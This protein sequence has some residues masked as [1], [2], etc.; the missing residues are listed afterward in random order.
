MILDL[1]KTTWKRVKFGDV[2]KNV[3][4][5]SSDPASDG[6][7]RVIAMEHLDPGELAILRWG[8]LEAGTT[9]TRRVTPGQTLFGKRRAYQRKVAYAEFDAICSG[10]ILTFEAIPGKLLP[11]LLPFIVQS[12]PFFERAVGTSAGSL[13]P[14]TNWRDLAKFEFDLPPLDQQKR[15]VDLLWAVERHSQSVRLIIEASIPCQ[16][17][18]MDVSADGYVELSDVLSVAKSGGTPRRSNQENY[19]GNIPWLKSGEV[20]GGRITSTEEL[21][22]DTGLSSSAAWLAPEGA[23]VVAMYGDGKT[24]GQVGRLATPM[25]TN[26]AVLALVADR[27]KADSRFL[28]FWLRSRQSEL[29]ERGAGA[30]QKNLSKKIVISEPFPDISIVDQLFAAERVE[31]IDKSTDAQKAELDHLRA[32]RTSLL[33]SIFGDS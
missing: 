6:I 3:N 32:L 18:A 5:K 12:D 13:S 29:R 4:T 10:D 17:L 27:E 21:I 30:A 28:Y 22:S 26:Q 25:A 7:D 16:A 15:I 24:R 9:F 31:T 11:E 1:D 19:L 33:S 20:V 23:T 8:S 2:V 14:R